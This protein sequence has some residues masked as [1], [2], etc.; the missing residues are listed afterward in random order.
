MRAERTGLFVVTC[1][2]ISIGIIM[3]YSASAI[4]AY[5]RYQDSFYFLKR[6]LMYLGVGF[7]AMMA[8]LAFPYRKIR[9]F[10]KPFLLTSIVLLLLVLISPL[11]KESGG[12]SRWFR[13]GPFSFQPSEAAKI[14][15]FIYLADILSRKKNDLDDFI[16]G[17]LPPLLVL[18]VIILLILLQPDLGTALTFAVVTLLM[19]FL[20]GV[21]LRYLLMTLASFLPAFLFLILTKPYRLRRIIAFLDPWQDPQGSGFQIIQSFLAL[22]SGGLSGVGLG[23]S[24]QKLFYLPACHTDFIFSIIGEELGLWGTLAVLFLFVLFSWYAFQ[25]L[26]RVQDRFGR[27][28]GFGIASVMTFEALVN[29]GVTCGAIPTKGLPLPFV[30]YGGSALVF[31]LVGVGL[32]LNIS[33]YGMESSSVFS[34]NILEAGENYFVPKS[35]RFQIWRKKG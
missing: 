13:V 1:A 25:M 3:I 31:N 8:T 22:G 35:L 4:Y 11:G 6:H 23:Q 29:I 24:K 33:R 5:E 34:S 14:A 27:L 9:Y 30:S 7:L 32:L 15:F 26:R 16:H 20:A 10:A 19:L 2:L 17:F 12:A 28:L 18:G 21:R